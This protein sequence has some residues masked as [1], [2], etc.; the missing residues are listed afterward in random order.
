[1]TAAARVADD[2]G[3]VTIN[4]NRLARDGLDRLGRIAAR[5]KTLYDPM[6][7]GT[8]EQGSKNVLDDARPECVAGL[9]EL[10][11]PTPI[12]VHCAVSTDGLK[13]VETGPG[14]R[15]AGTRRAGHTR[16]RQDIRKH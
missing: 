8:F 1:M 15:K 2:V 14:G 4:F 11:G 10:V 9:E 6:A 3:S 12:P 5:G 7:G 16:D 13:T